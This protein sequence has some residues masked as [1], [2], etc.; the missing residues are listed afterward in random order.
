MFL[1]EKFVGKILVGKC[2]WSKNVSSEKKTA[3]K[4]SVEN[5]FVR[6]MFRSKNKSSEMFFSRNI[7]S[8]RKESTQNNFGRKS[9]R[10]KEVSVEKHVHRKQIFDRK[11]FQ[12]KHFSVEKCF[13]WQNV[14][15]KKFGRFFFLV[16]HKFRTKFWS[17]NKFGR[18]KLDQLTMA[19][20]R[21]YFFAKMFSIKKNWP[22][23]FSAEN[24]FSQKNFGRKFIRPKTFSVEKSFGRK[25]FLLKIILDEKKST[26]R[27]S[28]KIPVRW[29]W[30][31]ISML[32]L[33]VGVLSTVLITCGSG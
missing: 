2:F 32:T 26:N 31:R 20:V 28:T 27:I 3:K 7:F 13:G 18:N 4:L 9:F 11:H 15:R 24:I 22:K 6:K 29:G 19:R 21:K 30:R 1:A 10:S 17:K 14:R 16:E 12:P 23:K 25:T 5:C 33:V 8:P